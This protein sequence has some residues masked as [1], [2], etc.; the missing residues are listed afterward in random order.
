MPGYGNPA[1]SAA[2]GNLAGM[3]VVASAGA[4]LLMGIGEAASAA[5]EAL[6][7]HRYVKA[8]NTSLDAAVAHAYEMEDL[9]RAAVQL[10]AELEAENTRLR[11]ACTQ[12]QEVIE[13]MLETL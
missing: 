10:V 7:E 2:M 5:G 11:I 3:A 8:Y 13:A 6:R 4:G 9:A 12:N 1:A